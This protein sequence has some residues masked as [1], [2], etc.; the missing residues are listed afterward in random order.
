MGLSS[1]CHSLTHLLTVSSIGQLEQ[2]ISQRNERK[3]WTRKKRTKR[4][5]CTRTQ[6]QRQRQQQQQYSNKPQ[7]NLILPQHIIL[8]MLFRK[9]F[10]FFFCCIFSSHT[11][12]AASVERPVSHMYMYYT[13]CHFLFR[14]TT[15]NMNT[16]AVHMC[17]LFASFILSFCVCVHR[18]QFGVR[19]SEQQRKS[20][21]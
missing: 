11:L 14:C 3:K 20:L 7:S 8:N 16:A 5:L 19:Y 2:I 18:R 10:F 17:G 12:A 9:S 1:L 15:Y 21:L 13:L 4:N 6:R